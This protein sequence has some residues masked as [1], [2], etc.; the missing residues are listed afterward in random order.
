[1]EMD[2]KQ[3]EMMYQIQMFE[4]Q[5]QQLQQQ[6]QMVEQGIGELDELS[7]GFDDLVGKKGEEILAQVGRG[8]FI[9]ANLVSEDLIVDIGGKKFVNKSIPETKEMIDKQIKKLEDVR[10]QLTASMNDL[11]AEVMKMLGNMEGGA[12][13]GKK[14]K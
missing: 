1:M 8:I 5:M 11:N 9:K 4:N 10:E 13:D 3:Q 12:G 7:K 14:D 2:E 6:L